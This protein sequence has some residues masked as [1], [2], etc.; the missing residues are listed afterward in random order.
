MTGFLIFLIIALIVVVMFQVT[1]TLDMVGQE[2][3]SGS[4]HV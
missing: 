4:L 1:K 3:I 2:K